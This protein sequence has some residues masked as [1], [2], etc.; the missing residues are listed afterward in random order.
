MTFIALIILTAG[1]L[2]PLSYGIST[3]LRTRRKFV[4]PLIRL[5]ARD[6]TLQPVKVAQ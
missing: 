4:Y 6:G 1:F 3:L 2:V 5:R